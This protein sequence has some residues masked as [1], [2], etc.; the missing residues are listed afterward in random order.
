MGGPIW[1]R[2]LHDQEWVSEL[3]QQMGAESGRYA[4]YARLKGI[5]TAV[6]EELPDAPLYYK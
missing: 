1:A 5:L 6:A 2:P 4:Q 3:L